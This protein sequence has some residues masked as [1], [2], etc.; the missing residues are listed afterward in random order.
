MES[1]WARLGKLGNQWK[2]FKIPK[3]HKM[4]AAMPSDQKIYLITEYTWGISALCHWNN[5]L[6]VSPIE[7]EI[8]KN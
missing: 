1:M 6:S 3:Y 4:Q 8:N 2:Y 5:A 7:R